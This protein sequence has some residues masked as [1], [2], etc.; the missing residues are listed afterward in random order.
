MIRP[1]D[2]DLFTLGTAEAL[3]E[4]RRQAPFRRR[5]IRSFTDEEALD[6]GMR[7]DPDETLAMLADLVRRI[8]LR[9]RS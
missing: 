7:D 5:T 2:E 4:G 9:W 8:A 6:A 1:L 3:A